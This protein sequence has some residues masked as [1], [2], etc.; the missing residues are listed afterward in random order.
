MTTYEP[1][2][3]LLTQDSIKVALHAGEPRNRDYMERIGTDDPYYAL[4]MRVVD[5]QMMRV[6]GLGHRDLGDYL[7][8]DAYEAGETPRELARNILENDDTY[9]A[10]FGGGLD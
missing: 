9:A 6:V 4:F 3:W 10:L 8:Y 5:Q 1:Q 7:T 2:G